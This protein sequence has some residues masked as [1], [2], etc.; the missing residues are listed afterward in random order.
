MRIENTVPGD[1]PTLGVVINADCDLE[2]GKL[3][4]V[5][6][7]LPMYPFKEYLTRF[8]APGHVTDV[9][10]TATTKILDIVGDPET[11]AADRANADQGL[12]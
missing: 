6:A 2:N 4:G 12:D 3:D 5:M 1:G 10:S 9:M 11:A 7:Y 8:W